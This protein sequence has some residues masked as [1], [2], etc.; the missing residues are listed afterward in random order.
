[1]VATYA[2]SENN[3]GV[4]K[5]CKKLVVSSKSK[6]CIIMYVCLYV[7]MYVCSYECMCAEVCVSVSGCAYFQLMGLP[8]CVLVR[9]PVCITNHVLILGIGLRHAESCTRL[10]I[11]LT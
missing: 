3:R 9:N 5:Q 6:V 11:G 1:M 10:P 2:C 7:C 4:Y 8:L